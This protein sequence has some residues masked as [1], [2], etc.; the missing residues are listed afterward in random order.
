MYLQEAEVCHG[1]IAG[2]VA[3]GC[4]PLAETV[5]PLLHHVKPF[6]VP[7]MSLQPYIPLLPTVE[8]QSPVEVTSP[9][10]VAFIFRLFFLL[11]SSFL[12]LR[13]KEERLT[14]VCTFV[15]PL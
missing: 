2:S 14:L 1:S 12:C 13:C 8:F 5:A 15:N 6:G 10:F 9:G 7:D 4:G 11:V 3:L